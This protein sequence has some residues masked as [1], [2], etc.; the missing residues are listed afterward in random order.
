MNGI[1]KKWMMKLMG[2]PTCE[3]IAEFSYAYLEHD[4]DTR[5]R[6]KFEEHLKGC[7][8]CRRFVDSY[9]EVARPER[10]ARPI[11]LNADFERRV[12][13]FLQKQR[14]AL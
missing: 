14:G 11:P 12:V 6:V 1:I 9:R 3:E 7:E 8:N 4:L 13:E 5:T 2:L 10:L